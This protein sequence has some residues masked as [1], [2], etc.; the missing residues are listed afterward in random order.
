MYYSI[1]LII[2]LIYFRPL[3][4][5]LHSLDMLSPCFLMVNFVTATCTVQ[6]LAVTFGNNGSWRREAGNSVPEFLLWA[7]RALFDLS[8]LALGSLSLVRY[9]VV[10][11]FTGMV[12]REILSTCMMLFT[13][14][15]VSLNL[16]KMA[17]TLRDGKKIFLKDGNLPEEKSSK[18][19]SAWSVFIS[20]SLITSTFK[21]LEG[22][23]WTPEWKV[24]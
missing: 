14:E 10:F 18:M 15:D 5:R 23:A 9:M 1:N 17:W 13:P 24:R 11:L 2:Y 7:S 20:S 12:G 4:L 21:G 3:N 16:S 19:M 6:L 8:D 22:L